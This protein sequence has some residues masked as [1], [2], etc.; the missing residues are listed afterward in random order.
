MR[1]Y[2]GIPKE[3]WKY[4]NFCWYMHDIIVSICARCEE[5]NRLETEI[6]FKNN[7]HVK[8]IKETKDVLEWLYKNDYTNEANTII[9]KKVFH[10]ILVDMLNFVYESLSTIE[11]GKIT[12]SLALLRKPFRD[13][14]LY[15]EWLLN[16]S[17][18]F[19]ELVYKGDIDTYAIEYIDKTDKQKKLKIIKNAIDKID[20]K[21]YFPMFNENI[22]FDIRYN[23]DADN[24]LQ[25]V[26][27]RANHLVTTRK[28]HRSNEFNFVF[29]N[30]TIHLDYVKYYYNQVPHLLFYTYNIITQ[31][32]HIKKCSEP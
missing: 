27:D 15:L 7:D 3:Y 24:S 19:I 16:D 31:T 4:Q 22:Y 29:L 8:K 28:H 21:K 25:K 20:N 9:G 23:K 14:L 26:W 2:K 13:N 10:A 11:R 32:S 1:D 5:N 18:E 30:D 6:V 12:V 17:N